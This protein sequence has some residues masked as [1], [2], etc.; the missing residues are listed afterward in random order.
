MPVDDDD[1]LDPEEIDAEGF[2]EEG[3]DLE[4]V[5]PDAELLE[6]DLEDLDDVELDEVPL[7]EED[8]EEE[9]ELNYSGDSLDIGFNVTYLIDVL[10]NIQNDKVEFSFADANS[11]C[12]VT[13]PGNSDY[14][15]VVM[16]MRI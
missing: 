13:I 2:I 4:E 8:A 11:S 9:L 15:Y 16:P 12:L 5:D 6:D 3:E 10:N 7:E 1:V 14:K